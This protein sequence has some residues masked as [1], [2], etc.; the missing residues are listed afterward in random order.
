MRLSTVFY[1]KGVVV[2]CVFVFFGWPGITERWQSGLAAGPWQGAVDGPT[3][4][5]HPLQCG[6]HQRLSGQ[7]D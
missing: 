5:N 3:P 2:V 6:L 4:S 1:N 7:V